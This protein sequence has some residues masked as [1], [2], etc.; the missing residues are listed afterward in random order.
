MLCVLL[1]LGGQQPDDKLVSAV[2]GFPGTI[3]LDVPTG[4]DLPKGIALKKDA[5]DSSVRLFAALLN[6]GVFEKDNGFVLHRRSVPGIVAGFTESH[7]VL[8]WLASCSE[9]ERDALLGGQ[10]A[11]GELSGEGREACAAVGRHHPGIATAMQDGSALNVG[12]YPIIVIQ[13]SKSGGKQLEVGM[14]PERAYNRDPVASLSGTPGAG[15]PIQVPTDGEL[16]FKDAVRIPIRDLVMQASLAFKTEY[17]YDGRFADTVVIVKGIFTK[18][19]FEGAVAKLLTA[20]PFREAASKDVQEK[21]DAARRALLQKLAAMSD[22]E[23]QKTREGLLGG[24][25][26]MT[27]DELRKTFPDLA[28]ASGLKGLDGSSKVRISLAMGIRIQGN[29]VSETDDKASIG[30]KPVVVTTPNDI[31]FRLWPW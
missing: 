28:G 18:A 19:R 29:G 30:G 4:Y 3:L 15:R 23:H 27:V 10:C 2:N 12:L 20:I 1:S 24:P 13:D 7:Q 6:R 9:R 5:T 22:D 8:N 14:W 26:E 31:R 16:S 25:K 21:A 11:F 17:A